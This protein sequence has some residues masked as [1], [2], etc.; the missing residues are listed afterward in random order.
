MVCSTA[1]LLALLFSFSSGFAEAI[2][3]SGGD[4]VENNKSS[5]L[6]THDKDGDGLS[7]DLE[8]M[9]VTNKSDKYGDKDG[10]GLYDFEEYLDYY[11]TPNDD[12]DNT[13]YRYNDATSKGGTLQDIYAIFNLT[14]NKAGYLRD[15][16]FTEQNG[17]FTNYLLWNVT[18]SGE[19]AGGSLGQ[20]VT[21]SNNV[22]DTVIFEGGR[23]GGSFFW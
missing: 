21:Y 19:R 12:T 17:G 7:D 11:G 8:D 5:I 18:F 2:E 6:S 23:A 9:L 13:T 3:K 1:F 15:T 10:D 20:S 22:L 14:S 4:F 16:V